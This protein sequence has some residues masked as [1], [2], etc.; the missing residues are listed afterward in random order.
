MK[1]KRGRKPKKESTPSI[2]R[3]NA[4]REIMRGEIPKHALENN[5]YSE[6]YAKNPAQF[7][8]TKAVK[9]LMKAFKAKLKEEKSAALEEMELKRAEAKYSELGKVVHDFT[10]LERLLDE[11]ATDIISEESIRKIE[12]DMKD[13]AEEAEEEEEK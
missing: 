3:E 6:H 12:G 13:L 9:K 4:V 11:K 8:N 7:V 10:K 2:R 1:D 5:G